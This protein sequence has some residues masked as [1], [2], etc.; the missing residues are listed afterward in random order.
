M[1]G[2][3]FSLEW[4]EQRHH[5]ARKLA[6]DL[7]VVSLL[8]TQKATTDGRDFSGDVYIIDFWN[9]GSAD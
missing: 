7:P 3:P 9:R 1:G 5:A 4:C 2:V 6:D 8:Q